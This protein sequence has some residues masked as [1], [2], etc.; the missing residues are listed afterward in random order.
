MVHVHAKDL[1]IDRD[2]L[3]ENGILSSEWAGRCRACQALAK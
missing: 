1:M 3:Y 2:G